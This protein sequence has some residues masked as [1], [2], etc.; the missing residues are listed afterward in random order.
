MRI[1]CF[2]FVFAAVCLGCT[3]LAQTQPTP[4]R[5]PELNYFLGDWDC[6]GKFTRSGAAIEAHQHFESILGDKFI[7]FRHDDKPPHNYHAWAE[8]GWDAAGK[9]FVSTIQD[10][11]GS[12]RTF[13]S[14]GWEKD[15]LV[16]EGGSP[17]N[18]PGNDEQF[19]FERITPKQFRVSYAA[20]KDGDWATVDVSTCT[21]NEKAG[22]RP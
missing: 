16:W 14:A 5:L 22:T 9:Q 21:Q 12:T 13:H 8:W 10:S 6:A 11:G 19:V 17:Q 15:R 1:V 3:A 2:Q 18:F 20:K 4:S 7:L